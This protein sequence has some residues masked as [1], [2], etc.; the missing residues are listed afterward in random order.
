MAALPRHLLARLRRAGA[1]PRKSSSPIK[2]PSARAASPTRAAGAFRSPGG[3]N[4]IVNPKTL[5]TISKTVADSKNGGTKANPKYEELFSDVTPSRTGEG[6]VADAVRSAQGYATKAAAD[7]AAQEAR[8]AAGPQTKADG[9]KKYYF[10]VA[11]GKPG[12]KKLPGALGPFDS[13]YQ[14]SLAAFEKGLIKKKPTETKRADNKNY[15]QVRWVLLGTTKDKNGNVRNDWHTVIDKNGEHKPLYGILQKNGG[16]GKLYTE[17]EKKAVTDAKSSST[18]KAVAQPSA[19]DLRALEQA[20]I[21]AGAKPESVRNA[22]SSAGRSM[23][24][25]AAAVRLL[26][27]KGAKQEGSICL[28]RVVNG[29]A[30]G[31]PTIVLKS[32]GSLASGARKLASEYALSQGVK[33]SKDASDAEIRKVLRAA[34][35]AGFF[36]QAFGTSADSKCAGRKDALDART[37]L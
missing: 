34:V 35:N 15:A 27:L 33:L 28:K 37:D 4:F 14:A 11:T 8:D 29:K 31:R 5:R 18:K 13:K 26:M 36:Q 24:Q 3:G 17:K 22:A 1:S 25:R 9:P 19:A 21:A 30:T 23:A 32:D 16:L 12:Q 20:A 10:N 7:A 2:K 6:S